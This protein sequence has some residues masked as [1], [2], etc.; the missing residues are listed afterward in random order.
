MTASW[1][2]LLIPSLVALAMLAV[3]LA[4]GTWQVERLQWKQEILRQVAESERNPPVPLSDNPQPFAKVAVT[5][6]FH[7]ELSALYAADVRETASGP[8][9]GARLIVPLERGGAEPPVLVDRGWVPVRRT[10]PIDQPEGIVTVEGYVR[11]GDTASW[12]SAM[13]DVPGRHF[14]TLDPNRIGSALGLPGVAPFV[15]VAMG[16]ERRGELPIPAQALPRPPNN[17][18]SYAITWYGLAVALVVVFVVWIRKERA[19]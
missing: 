11:P 12:F 17:H 14:Y 4:L 7:P 10:E 5:G 19:A 3:L 6:R 16:P 9:M 2:R 15:V 8:Q 13:D 1:Q 18:L